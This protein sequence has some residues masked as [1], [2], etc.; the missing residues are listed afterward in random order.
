VLAIIEAPEVNAQLQQTEADLK[1]AEANND[2]AQSTATRWIDLLK[3]N[4]VS[5]QETDVTI[6]DAKAK[7]AIV[8]SMRANRDRLR[9]LVSFQQVVAPFD[10]VIMSRTTDVGR[11]INAG[12]GP[13]PLFRLVQ[14]DRLRIYVR[15]PQDYAARIVS[16][17]TATL[18][19]SEHPDKTYTASLLDT[20]KAIDPNTRTLL[21]QLVTEN[22]SNELLPGGYVQVHLQLPG[23]KN[24]VR[25]PVNTLLFRA[26]GLQVA[27]MDGSN[28]VVLKQ[29]KIGRDF[30]DFIEVSAGIK[31]GEKIILNPTDSIMAGQ[32]VRIA[33]QQNNLQGN[34]QT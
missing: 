31:P 5:K 18:Q 16:N 8:V 2:L 4:S 27:T 17:L 32:Q 13:M 25:L 15:V 14:T 22:Q 34:N 33:T 7:Q 20:A 11:L 29:I 3:T 1:T 24:I 26:D 30:G 12:S 19:F 21:I 10:G 9:D 28:K 23:D 6:G